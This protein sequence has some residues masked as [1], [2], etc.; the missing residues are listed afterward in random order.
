MED[1]PLVIVAEIDDAIARFHED[2]KSSSLWKGW[3][4]A[5]QWHCLAIMRNSLFL[6]IDEAR[7][8]ASPLFL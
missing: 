4:I 3:K 1:L 5:S 2:R 6:L 8:W 7:Q